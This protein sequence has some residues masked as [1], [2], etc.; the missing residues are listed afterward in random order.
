MI[1]WKYRENSYFYYD[2]MIRDFFDFLRKKSNSWIHS[3]RYTES[4]SLGDDWLAKAEKAYKSSVE[5]CK[6]ERDNENNL[7]RLYWKNIFDSS[8]KAI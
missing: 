1:N 3:H 5:A 6:C 2:W 4:F 8:I 7:A